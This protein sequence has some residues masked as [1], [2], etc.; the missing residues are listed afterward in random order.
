MPLTK[1]G[2]KVLNSMKQQYG[3]EK[4]EQL[5]HASIN[6]GV[7]GSEKWHSYKS[8]KHKRG[9]RPLLAGKA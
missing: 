4:G 1:A 2:E 7:A 3:F 5:F 8:K 9:S 6:K